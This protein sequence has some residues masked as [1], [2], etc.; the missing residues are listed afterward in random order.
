MLNIKKAITIPHDHTQKMLCVDTMHGDTAEDTTGDDAMNTGQLQSAIGSDANR[1][2]ISI[3]LH[4]VLLQLGKNMFAVRV[5]TQHSDVWT[6]LVDEQFALWWIG[7]VNH[8]LYDVVG[9]LVF[10]HRV[11][12]RLRPTNKAHNMTAPSNSWYKA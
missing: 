11:Q 3:V 1:R 7:N 4:V 9:K 12:C 5:L 10:H 8:T 2:K 6:D